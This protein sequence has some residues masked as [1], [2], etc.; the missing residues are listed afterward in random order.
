MTLVASTDVL[1]HRT[2]DYLQAARIGLEP[3]TVLVILHLTPGVAVAEEFT[4]AL[5]RDRDGSLSTDEQREYARQV[6]SALKVEMD[7]RALRPRVVSSGFPGLSAFGR[8]EGTI[9][10]TI[11]ATLPRVAPGSHQ[12][13]FRNQHLSAHSAYLANALV[14]ESAGLAVTGQRR[15]SDQSELTI[16]FTVH[17]DS[18]GRANDRR[19]PPRLPRAGPR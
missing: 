19:R 3:D 8:G 10:M 5:D 9:R 7:G 2:E 18:P 14:P 12:L 1:A 11:Q 6:V 4:A 13:F 15:T 16:E 17:A